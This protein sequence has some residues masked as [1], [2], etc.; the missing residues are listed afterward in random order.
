MKQLSCDCTNL[1]PQACRQLEL[2][3]NTASRSQELWEAMGLAQHHDAVSGTE[4]Q[5]VADDYAR[6]L[7][8]GVAVCRDAVEEGLGALMGGPALAL[9]DC[10]YLNQS[11]CLAT[12]AGGCS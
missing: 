4:K 12:T 5:H 2:Q 10:P 9:S 6:H 7:S 3:F 8:E 11:V 1:I